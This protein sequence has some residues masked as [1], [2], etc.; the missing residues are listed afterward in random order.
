[1]CE[2]GGPKRFGRRDGWVK[3]C[4]DTNPFERRKKIGGQP[5]AAGRTIADAERERR[6]LYCI[7][8]T[9]RRDGQ[10]HALMGSTEALKIEN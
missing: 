10:R 8:I 3:P 5:G 7:I 1:V 9:L 2:Q 4:R 6:D